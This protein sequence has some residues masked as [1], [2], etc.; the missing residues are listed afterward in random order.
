[1]DL[2]P[3]QGEGETTPGEGGAGGTATVREYAGLYRGLG[4]GVL[5]TSI[6]SG[7]GLE[8]LA[9]IL[10]VG[11]SALVGP[12]GVGKSSLLNAIEPSLGLRTG[13]LSHRK[14]HG[15]HT[16]V[17]ARLIPLACGGLVADTPGF[18]DVGVWGV[19]HREI[20]GCFPDFSPFREECQF[21]ECTH[22]HEPSCG[23]RAALLRGEIHGGR[24]ESYRTLVQ[25]A[26]GP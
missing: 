22:L 6:V 11:S 9:K 4:Y 13:E 15:R 1:M 3:P 23:V 10:C 24:F 25:E 2:L 5:E 18:T 16:T 20:E 12:S 19:D 14:G 21:R 26:G 7:E 8:A 17:S